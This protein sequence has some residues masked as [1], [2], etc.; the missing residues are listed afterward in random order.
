MAQAETKGNGGKKGKPSHTAASREGSD[1]DADAGVTTQRG[2]S[3]P[4][5]PQRTRT[6]SLDAVEALANNM[7][8]EEFTTRYKSVFEEKSSKRSSVAT[9]AAPHTPSIAVNTAPT[10]SY[11]YH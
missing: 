11:H 9:T 8:L 4:S 3:V 1:N 6:P 2:S 5:R 10:S 7:S